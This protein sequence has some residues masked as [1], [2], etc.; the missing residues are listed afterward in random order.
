VRRVPG[1]FVTAPDAPGGQAPAWAPFADLVEAPSPDGEAILPLADMPAYLE[2]LRRRLEACGGSVTRLPIPALPTRGLVVNCS[3]TS[4]RALA[5]DPDVRPLRHQSLVLEDPGLDAWT[6]EPGP[7]GLGVLPFG[8]SVLVAGPVVAD[9]WSPDP[10]LELAAELH[11]RAVAMVPRL[12]DAAVRGHR[13]GL[14]PSRPQVRLEVERPRPDDS[15]HV[16]VHCY[17]H[18]GDVLPG[19]A[20]PR[21]AGGVPASGVGG[22]ATAWGCAGDL[23]DVVRDLRKTLSPR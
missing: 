12:R 3:G 17:G 16:V 9:E 2:Y 11:R 8:N 6:V 15:D 5:G 22:V 1:R 4:A 21:G 23:V 19:S 18:A 7:A 20:A 10:D 13:V 14:L